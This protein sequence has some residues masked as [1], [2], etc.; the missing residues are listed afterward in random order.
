M[1][2]GVAGVHGTIDCVCSISVLVHLMTVGTGYSGMTLAFGK[3][4]RIYDQSILVDQP[5][6]GVCS[7]RQQL[8][9]LVTG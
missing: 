7:L 5:L 4:V 8:N 6:E 9:A 2:T 3:G 1:M